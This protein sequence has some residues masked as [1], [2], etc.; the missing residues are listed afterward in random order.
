MSLTIEGLDDNGKLRLAPRD[1]GDREA[2][3]RSRRMV[4]ERLA[5]IVPAETAADHCRCFLFHEVPPLEPMVDL[6]L[7]S[8][9]STMHRSARATGTG[10]FPIKTRTLSVHFKRPA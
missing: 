1:Q 8:R 5:E 2:S 3:R 10:G 7:A 6:P 9:R 4:D